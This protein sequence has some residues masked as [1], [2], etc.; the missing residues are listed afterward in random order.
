MLSRIRPVAVLA[1]LLIA[2]LATSTS[3]FAQINSYGSGLY[4]S[5]TLSTPPDQRH[6][7]YWD[8]T[9]QNQHRQDR[10]RPDPADA[11]GRAGHQPVRGSPMNRARPLL[12]ILAAG[13]LAACTVAPG[14]PVIGTWSGDPPGPDPSTPETVTLTLYGLPTATSG[15]YEIATLTHDEDIGA[16]LSRQN[17][18]SG[19]WTRALGTDNNQPRQIIYLHDALASDI[20]Q[21]AIGPGNTLQPTSAYLHRDLTRQE[22]ALFTL[23]PLTGTLQLPE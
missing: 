7:G 16:P 23:K 18:W 14:Q 12:A 10:P 5:E 3:A 13:L 2:G 11:L 17:V 4:S 22:T 1:A 6:G 20:N 21:Y 9:S 19:R 15:E 8:S